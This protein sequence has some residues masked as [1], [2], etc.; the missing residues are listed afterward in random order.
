MV[1]KTTFPYILLALVI[2]FFLI[3]EGCNQS[4]RNDMVADIANYKTQAEHYRGVNGVEVAKNRALMLDNQ[5]QIEELLGKNDT[6]TELM[7]KYKDLKN[8][9][10]INNTTEI[11]NDSI[12]YDTI[13]IPCDFKPFQVRRDSSHYTF[14][15]TIGKDYFKIDSLRIPDEQSIVFGK[16]KTG[17]LK[18]PEYTAEV[19]HSN[20][21]I[22]TNNIGSYAV[23]E[24]RKK[25]VISAGATW[26]FAPEYGTTT[27]VIGI[28]AGF[29]IISW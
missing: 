14:A 9:T 25:V 8:V 5:K 20:P 26:G 1:N 27:T 24:K 22:R 10:I 6:L 17:F 13:K 7:K 3:R 28:N 2:V 12:P 15:G 29:P 19:V 21:L 23:K 16:R 18:R 11:S 4:S